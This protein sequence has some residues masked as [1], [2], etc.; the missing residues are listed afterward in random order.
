MAFLGVGHP[1]LENINKFPLEGTPPPLS[2]RETR[3]ILVL[4]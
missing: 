2:F 1:G 4:K 3:L